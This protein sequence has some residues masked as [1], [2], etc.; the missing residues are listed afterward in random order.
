MVGKN[1]AEGGRAR[2][3]VG[4]FFI[5]DKHDQEMIWVVAY[6]YPSPYPIPDWFVQHLY[7]DPP[8]M[9]PPD[10]GGSI[11]PFVVLEGGLV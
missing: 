8:Q 11:F 2:Y 4:W 6:P 5:E 1:P 7:N 10:G 9:P 3:F